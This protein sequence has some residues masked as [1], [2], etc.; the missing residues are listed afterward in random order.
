MRFPTG[1]AGV[2]VGVDN[3]N[4]SLSEIAGGFIINLMT[5][6]D[7]PHLHSNGPT[8]TMLH[9]FGIGKK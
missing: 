3:L 6:A 2:R 1:S 9:K 7:W 8:P 5:M 4:N